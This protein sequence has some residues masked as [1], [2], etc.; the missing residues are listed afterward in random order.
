MTR[1]DLRED[2][3][4]RARIRHKTQFNRWQRRKIFL[5]LGRDW[6]SWRGT[7][8][9]LPPIA[10][11][12]G[13]APRRTRAGLTSFAAVPIV[14]VAPRLLLAV[15]ILITLFVRRFLHP[16]GQH[17]QVEEI[18]RRLLLRHMCLYFAGARL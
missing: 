8:V 11:R 13:S 4:Q 12:V 6:S 17:P 5:A 2:I 16:G 3:F 15:K 9:S 1:L 14:A 7:A 10:S 18:G